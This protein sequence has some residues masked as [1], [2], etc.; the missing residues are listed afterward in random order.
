RE[1]YTQGEERYDVIIDNVG[2]RSLLENKR[3]LDADGKYIL[4]GGGGPDAGNWVG[5]LASPVKM[6]FLA[7]F[8]SQ[9]MKI[10]LAELN[11]EDL[12]LLGELIQAGKVT[13]VIDRRYP[14]SE[15]PAAIDY[16]EQGHARGKV[17][18]TME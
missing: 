15:V 7:P 16:L 3:I 5:P 9:E 12:N 13:P 8:V 17:L 14:L 1:D 11:Q 10:F 18:I 4:I 2:N 6:L